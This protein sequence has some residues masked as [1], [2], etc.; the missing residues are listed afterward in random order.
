M[1]ALLQMED[2]DHVMSEEEPEPEPCNAVPPTTDS[3]TALSRQ[4]SRKRS[5]EAMAAEA[6]AASCQT[7]WGV[8]TLHTVDSLRDTWDLDGFG[9]SIL[10][11]M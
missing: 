10:Q 7:T 1:E 2:A 11:I 3:V 5:W 6:Q 4:P 8:S 9:W